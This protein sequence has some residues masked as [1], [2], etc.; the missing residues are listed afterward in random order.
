[1]TTAEL[2]ESKSQTSGKNQYTIS[3]KPSKSGLGQFKRDKDYKPH[4]HF[5]VEESPEA[6]RRGTNQIFKK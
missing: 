5:N 3:K 2:L 4:D 6:K 1:M